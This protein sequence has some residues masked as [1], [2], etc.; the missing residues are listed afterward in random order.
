MDIIHNCPKC[1]SGNVEY[2]TEYICNGRSL[3]FASFCTDCE[4]TFF[5]TLDLVDTTIEDE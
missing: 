1:G 5:Q 4:T 3:L 2:S